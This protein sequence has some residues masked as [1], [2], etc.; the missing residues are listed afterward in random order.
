M[1]Q[2]T[3]RKVVSTRGVG[4]HS[5]ALLPVTLRPAAERTG[6]VFRRTDVGAQ[7]IPGTALHVVD[8]RLCTVVGQGGVT[9]STVEHIMAALWSCGVDN[10]VVDVGG[11]EVPVMDGSAAPWVAL[12]EEAGVVGQAA[13]RNMLVCARGV[14]VTEGDKLAA[15]QPGEGLSVTCDIDFVHPAIGPQH[16]DM[17]LDGAEFRRN[18]AAAR[19]FGFVKDVEALRKVGLARGGSL[20]NA[21]VLDDQRILNPEGL[22]YSDEFVRHKVLDALGDL[23]LLGGH[24]VGHVTLRKAGH[25]LHNRLCRALLAEEALEQVPATEFARKVMVPVGALMSNARS[26]TDSTP[27]PPY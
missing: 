21:V 15:L 12:I 27:P 2:Q 9:L 3:L 5:G 13:A 23:F 17:S 6:I 24:L 26:S 19:T 10:A 11:P 8:T 4:L 25:A 22:R 14:S 1:M 16:L 20:E 18:L 7:E